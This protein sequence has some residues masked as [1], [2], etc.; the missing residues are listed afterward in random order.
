MILQPT[1]F[2]YIDGS[3]VTRNV[4][5]SVLTKA[6]TFNTV[7]T[8][9]PWGVSAV[10]TYTT[11]LRIAKTLVSDG[12]TALEQVYS[13]GANILLMSDFR[14]ATDVWDT[15]ANSMYLVTAVKSD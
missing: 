4:V 8:S 2:R 1:F 13:I 12:T 9:S 14:V 6:A 5:L 10:N 15:T 7:R 11:T 3:A